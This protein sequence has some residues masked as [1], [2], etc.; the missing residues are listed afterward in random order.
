VVNELPMF[1][2]F[3]PR[4]EGCIASGDAKEVHASDAPA[5]RGRN[6]LVPRHAGRTMQYLA[7]RVLTPRSAQGFLA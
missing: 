1:F 7:R 3:Q 5:G 2:H 4:P 6:A